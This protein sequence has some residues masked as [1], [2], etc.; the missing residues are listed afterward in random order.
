MNDTY[1]SVCCVIPAGLEDELPELLASWSILG[2][3][4]DQISDR[5][6]RVAVYLNGI[7]RVGAHG[8]SRALTEAGATE[9]ERGVLEAEDWLAGFRSHLAPFEVGER[10]WVDP[11]PDQPTAAP[12]GRQRLVVEPRMAFGTGTHESTRAILETLEDIDVN[13]RT[14]LDVGT[15]SG[16]L[17]FAAE[18]LGAAGVV[19]LDIDPTAVWVALETA[20]QQEWRSTVSFVVGGVNCLRG[21]NFDIVV[22][23]MIASSFL[24]L[25]SDLRKALAPTGVAVF[26]GLLAAEV[27]SVS[28]AFEAT[29]FAVRS[30][31]FDG[32]W[33]SLTAV[34]ATAP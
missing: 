15:G 10:W 29:G 6:V 18:S 21:S 3:E 25:L 7:D 4:I 20:R 31:R 27:E 23:N 8:V 28:T 5:D 11:H 30:D 12:A 1:L 33:A 24:P 13:G 14:V 26:S 16:I 19:G 17:A 22:C 9:I 2:T 34:V 32:E